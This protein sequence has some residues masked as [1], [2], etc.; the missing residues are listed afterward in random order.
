MLLWLTLKGPLPLHNAGGVV[1]R[2]GM[3]KVLNEKQGPA[4]SA[5]PCYHLCPEPELNRHDPFGPQDFKSCVSTNSTIRADPARRGVV[6]FA[7]TFFVGRLLDFP[8]ERTTKNESR[9][10]RRGRI[11]EARVGIEPTYRSFADSCLTTWLP[12]PEK[13]LKFDAPT[14]FGPPH[15]PPSLIAQR[16][17]G[18]HRTILQGETYRSAEKPRQIKSPSDFRS[19]VLKSNSSA[20][21]NT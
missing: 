5:N 16:M 20:Y 11:F 8:E 9:K 12:R 17:R 19:S 13:I 15:T 2:G 10:I 1:W 21:P 14:K 7:F 6:R 4:R 3:E 18:P